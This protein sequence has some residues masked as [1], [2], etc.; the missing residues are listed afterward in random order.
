MICK[1]RARLTLHDDESD[2]VDALMTTVL[3]RCN[4]EKHKKSKAMAKRAGMW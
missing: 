4:E 1:P 2:A 3:E